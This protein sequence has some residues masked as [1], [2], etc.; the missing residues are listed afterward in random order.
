[1]P[2]KVWY[3]SYDELNSQVL[4]LRQKFENRCKELDVG[5]NTVLGEFTREFL[6]RAVHESNWQ[7]GL[8]LDPGKTQ[9]L[10]SI[11]FDE[12][13]DV[14]GPHLDMNKLLRFH[15]SSV[16]RMKRE[17]ATTE[18]IGAYNL[19]RAHHA[20][21]WVG[22]ELAGRQIALLGQALRNFQEYLPLFKKNASAEQLPVIENGF[23]ILEKLESD[24]TPVD[25]PMTAPQSTMGQM[26]KELLKLEF[27]S[28]L[29]PM[30]C[31]YIHFLHRLVMMGI[32]PPG[33]TGRFRKISVHVGNF[34]LYF[35]APSAVPNIMKEYCRKFPTIVPTVV[36]GDVIMQAAR[37]SHRFAAIHPYED[38]N[39]RVSRLIMNLVL[40]GHFPPVYLKADK[41]GRHRYGQ[42]MR[43][44]DR[45]DLQPLA[46]LIAMSLIE[47]YQRLLQ[48]LGRAR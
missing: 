32:M 13:E 34:D 1:M 40:W 24:C 6:T 7:E 19:A 35:P 42:A 16:I 38:G 39:G 46:A 37:A 27:D 2:G 47:I 33:R 18:E 5:P 4:D 21:V 12:M 10:A 23:A 43:R 3:R 45:G 36:K 15:R 22:G 11:A 29:H 28:L 20:I 14:A 48:S 25:I 9:E 31:S 26:L 30:R 41:K 44:G 17:G 8:E